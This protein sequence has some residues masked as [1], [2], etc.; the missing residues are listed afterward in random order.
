VYS[1]IL[2]KFWCRCT[3]QYQ[4]SWGKCFDDILFVATL[5]LGLR[6]RQRSCKVAGQ[7]EAQESHHILSGVWE[8]VKEW[9]LTLPRQLPLWEME[10]QWTP[11]TLESNFRGQNSI[12]CGVLY[13][14]EKLLELRCLKWA[15]I[16]HLDIR[17][18]SYGQK[19]GRE[20]N[21]Q[22]DSRLE[23]V[24]NRPELLSCRWC[25]TYC[26]KALDEG[27]N[28]ALDCT[29]IRGLLAKLCGSKVTRVLVRAI[30]GLP[31]R[32]PEREKPFG[33]AIWMWALWR[34]AEYTIRGKVVASPKS[35]PW[36]ILCVRV[37]RGSF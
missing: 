30:S 32:S 8:N 16:A 15:R 26:W 25:A 37:A 31:L 28:F 12:A 22:F 13:I 17:S 7:K 36:W 18:T 33:K 35:G 23:K 29:S 2:G 1:I 14:I 6:P 3:I 9:T 20:S 5:A 11:E 24:G 27:Y 19:K 4:K 21:C 34:G 10:S